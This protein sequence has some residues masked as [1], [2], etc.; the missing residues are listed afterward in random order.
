[1]YFIGIDVSASWLDLSIRS[2]GRKKG[3]SHRFDNDLKGFKALLK[4]VVGQIG[5]ASLAQSVFILEHTGLYDLELTHFLHSKGLAYSHCNPVEIQYSLGIQ[6]GKNDRID[7]ARIAQYGQEKGAAIVLSQ[8]ASKE[9]ITLHRLFSQRDLLVKNRTTLKNHNAV[10]KRL[11]SDFGQKRVIRR[12]ER[13]IRAYNQEVRQIEAE[14][15]K[16]MN[17]DP[18]LK[19]NYTLLRSV[20]GIGLI[21]SVLLLIRTKNFRAFS[22]WRQFACYAGTAP[23]EHRSG[24][25]I[26]KKSKVSQ[27]ANKRVKA[28]LS[29]AAGTAVQHCFEFQAFYE[30]KLQEGKQPGWI[31]NAIRNKIISRVFA[32]IKRQTPYKQI[33]KIKAYAS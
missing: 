30:K 8:P 9:L 4:W 22:T 10:L 11:K 31:F 27:M 33:D 14:F 1:M 6:R 21:N 19:Q 17:Q 7:A 3:L 25:S 28:L 26:K 12:N 5:T 23:F 13:L 2:D 29:R 15:L 20:P 16:L 18:T 32:V 24:S